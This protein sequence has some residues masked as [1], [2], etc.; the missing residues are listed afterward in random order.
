M[1]PLKRISEIVDERVKL[2]FDRVYEWAEQFRRIPWLDGVMVG[3]VQT[4]GAGNVVLEH[5]LGRVPRGFIVVGY[6]GAAADAYPSM[7]SADVR[8]M[9]V[10]FGGSTLATL[11]VWG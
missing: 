7:V 2:A 3:P 4:I 10:N 9:T 6:E 8:F 11:W 1:K 5:K